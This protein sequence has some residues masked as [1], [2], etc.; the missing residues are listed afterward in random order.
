MLLL[1]FIDGEHVL[2]R[3]ALGRGFRRSR[4]R[5][6]RGARVEHFSAAVDAPYGST[7]DASQEI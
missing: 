1:L 2:E 3:A 5:S 4:R 6:S 7:S